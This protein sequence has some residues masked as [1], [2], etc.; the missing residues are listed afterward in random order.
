MTNPAAQ[1]ADPEIR[2]QPRQRQRAFSPISILIIAILT[3][4]LLWKS[5]VFKGKPHVAV[6]TA[7]EGPYWDPVIA[8]AQEAARQSGVELTIVRSKSDK[9][10]QSQ[11][12]QK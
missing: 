9:D 11:S 10:V 2:S 5:D 7:G 12:I 6:V 1:T 3:G 8:G 4:L